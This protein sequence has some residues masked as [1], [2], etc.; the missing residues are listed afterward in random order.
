MTILLCAVIFLAG[1]FAGVMFM[2]LV[3]INHDH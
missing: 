2:A 1:S 3:Q